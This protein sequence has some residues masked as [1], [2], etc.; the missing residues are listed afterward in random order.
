MSQQQRRKMTPVR[1]ETG[2]FVGDGI[3]GS[4]CSPRPKKLEPHH[5]GLSIGIGSSRDRLEPLLRPDRNSFACV[6]QC[7]TSALFSEAGSALADTDLGTIKAYLRWQLVY[8]TRHMP[9]LRLWMRH[10]LLSSVER[11]V[12]EQHNSRGENVVPMLSM[13]N[14][15]TPWG[16]FMC[17]RSFHPRQDLL[18]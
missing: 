16:S 9:Y 18:H 5:A 8:N 3:L 14:S 10:T 12:A 17:L 4:N 13:P 15:A 7:G 2:N 1:S 11:F 6:Y